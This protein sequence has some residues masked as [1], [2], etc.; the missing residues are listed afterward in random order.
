[1]WTLGVSL[2]LA[3]LRTFEAT[4]GVFASIAMFPLS[5][6]KKVHNVLVSATIYSSLHW[7]AGDRSRGVRRFF[8]G[9]D[10]EKTLDVVL[11]RKCLIRHEKRVKRGRAVMPDTVRQFVE[12]FRGRQK[13]RFWWGSRSRSAADRKPPFF[14]QELLRHKL[15]HTT[16]G[17]QALRLF[18][19][20]SN[21]VRLANE[22]ENS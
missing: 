22:L 1:M 4:G 11:D 15:P 12:A 6:E 7:K 14:S 2:T 20:A 3:S 8:Y 9:D 10:G 17:F 21:F 18:P 13:V 16:W 19:Y 5:G